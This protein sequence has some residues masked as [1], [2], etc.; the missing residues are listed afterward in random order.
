MDQGAV[1]NDREVGALAYNPGLAK[2]NH[3]IVA[4]VRRFVVGLPIKMLVFEEHYRI[5]TTNRRSQQPVRIQRVRRID[6]AQARNLGEERHARLRVINRAAFQISTDRNPHYHRRREF[7]ARAPAQQ[8][9]LVAYLVKGRPD[10]IKELNLNHRL[11]AAR[12]HADGPADNIC[13]RQRRIE[14]ARAAEF[15]LQVGSNF[16]NAAFALDLSQRFFARAISDVFAECDQARIA[17]HLSVQAT[18]DQIDHRAGIA[19]EFNDVFGIKLRRSRIDGWRIDKIQNC[20]GRRLWT[21]QREVGSFVDGRVD[22]V[23]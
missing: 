7:I 20:L 17:F 19:A 4:R 11:Q 10:V 23:F 6:D 5:V 18:I 22:F 9:Q 21:G 3:E 12:G 8:R 16:E 13:F 2:R 14:N 15:A 1:G